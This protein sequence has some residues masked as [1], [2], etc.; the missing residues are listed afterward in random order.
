VSYEYFFIFD[1][2]KK[3]LVQKLRCDSFI[4]VAVLEDDHVRV[5]IWDKK[6]QKEGFVKFLP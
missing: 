6:R 4:S 1:I 5:K 2:K 3:K